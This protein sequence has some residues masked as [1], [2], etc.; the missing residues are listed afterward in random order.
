M[1]STGS[2]LSTCLLTLPQRSCSLEQR[3]SI[4]EAML[5]LS[6][7][8]VSIP[9]SRILFSKTETLL[10]G[11]EGAHQSVV[12]RTS[13]VLY[14]GMAHIPADVCVTVQRCSI[15]GQGMGYVAQPHSQL[16][17]RW[18]SSGPG[19][20]LTL[21]YL[22][23]LML[24]V[25]LP[26]IKI[27]SLTY[28]LHGAGWEQASPHH[29]HQQKEKQRINW[30]SLPWLF[31]SWMSF[32]H[33]DHP[34]TSQFLG[35]PAF[36]YLHNFFLSSW[37]MFSF[38]AL[39]ISCLHLTWLA[40]WPFLFSFEYFHFWVL[41]SPPLPNGN[42]PDFSIES[43]LFSASVQGLYC[44]LFHLCYTIYLGFWYSIFEQSPGSW[45]AFELVFICLINSLIST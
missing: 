11:W 17:S 35:P 28:L 15:A 39:Q 26:S 9:C 4:T 13:S 5:D 33:L 1:R 14:F 27:A 20:L 7:L 6:Q 41:T 24:I 32:L 21:T 2:P 23:L 25:G 31:H 36:E 44:S 19:D 3:F 12:P 38:L 37:A 45:K 29:L 42:L 16:T 8:A 40:L 30:A 43:F 18:T 10:Q 34:T 22:S